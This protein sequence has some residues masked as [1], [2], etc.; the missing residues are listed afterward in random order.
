M[1]MASERSIGWPRRL[2]LVALFVI[3]VVVAT[4]SG[5]ATLGLW[6]RPQEAHL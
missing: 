2:V 6:I 5:A 4:P 3:G 1:T